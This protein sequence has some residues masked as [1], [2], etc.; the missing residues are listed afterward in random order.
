MIANYIQNSLY[1]ILLTVLLTGCFKEDSPIQ[2]V[3]QNGVSI[4]YSLYN[5]Q[6]FYDFSTNMMQSNRNDKWDI[7]FENGAKGWHIRINYSNYAGIYRTESTDFKASSY[8][9]V[10]RNWLYDASS[11]NIDSTAIGNWKEVSGEDTRVY[12]FG[13]YDGVRY[14]PY[15]KLKFLSVSDTSYVFA[16]SSLDNSDVDTVTIQKNNEFNYVYF[17]FNKRDTVKIE[18]AKTSWDIVFTQYTTTLYTDEGIPTPYVVRGVYLNPYNVAAAIDTITNFA[19]ITPD[20]L[21][22]YGFYTK[23]DYIGYKWKSVEINQSANSARYNVNNTY[24]Y[25]IKD[26]DNQYFKFR[27]LSYVN[28]SLIVGFP[29]FEKVKL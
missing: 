13:I 11:G 14:N 22:S 10:E 25:L 27:F 12:L 28:D 20:L 2:P 23:Q 1:I 9:I 8:P 7:A 3:S 4:A 17:S 5:Y 16:Y 19:K 18:P 21:P 6:T 24:S 29:K 15:R 26:L